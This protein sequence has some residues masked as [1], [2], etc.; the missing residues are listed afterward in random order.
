[1]QHKAKASMAPIFQHAR[2][3]SVMRLRIRVQC[4]LL[5]HGCTGADLPLPPRLRN[6]SLQSDVE[7]LNCL[8]PHA[9]HSLCG[10]DKQTFRLN[11]EPENILSERCLTLSI[12][13][14]NPQ[15]TDKNTLQLVNAQGRP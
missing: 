3:V 1:M 5:T 15:N 14:A 13:A 4:A 9:H 12:T 11:A 7:L 10:S 6:K 8:L 2:K